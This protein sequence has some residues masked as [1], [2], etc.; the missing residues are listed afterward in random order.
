VRRADPFEQS[1]IGE[2]MTPAP[3]SA[4]ELGVQ[5]VNTD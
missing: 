2:R 5:L 3:D 1:V 4:G